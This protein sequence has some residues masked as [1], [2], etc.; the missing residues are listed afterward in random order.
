MVARGS[1]LAVDSWA[2]IGIGT[3][4]EIGIEFNRFDFDSDFDFDNGQVLKGYAYEK[5][6][7]LET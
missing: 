5:G 4:I 3:D 2:M 7:N 6:L 1:W